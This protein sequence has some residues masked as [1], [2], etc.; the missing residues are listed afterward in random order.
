MSGLRVVQISDVHLGLIVRHKL[1]K[2]ILEAVQ[3]ANPDILVSTGDLV[4]GQINRLEGLAEMLQNIK[5]P[6]W[7]ICSNRQP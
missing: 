4:D 2:K 5:P 6:L 3:K 1:L 7:Q